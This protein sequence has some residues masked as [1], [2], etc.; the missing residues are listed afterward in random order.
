MARAAWWALAAIAAVFSVWFGTTATMADVDLGCAKVPESGAAYE[1][2][3]RVSAVL[4]TWPLLKLGFLLTTP[5]MVAA[6][7]ER[8]WVS[9]AAVVALAAVAVV[10]LATWTG[11]W[12][13]LLFAA[14]LAVLGAIVTAVQQAQQP[15]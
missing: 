4:G 11:F 10:G 3:D 8:V 9:C 13:T 1:C 15:V 14:P 7:A 6:V 12:G 5:P 2:G